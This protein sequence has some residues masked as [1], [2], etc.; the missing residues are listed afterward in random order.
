MRTSRGPLPKYYTIDELAGESGLSV[1]I[2]RYYQ[3]RK[4]LPTRQRGKGRQER[5][6]SSEVDRLRLA[7]CAQRM[8]VPLDEIAEIL[9]PL[10]SPVGDKRTMVAVTL[11]A[12]DKRIREL[13][14]FR[15]EFEELLAAYGANASA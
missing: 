2:I 9:A 1:E 4:L 14:I 7:T 11:S 8:G 15:K 13:Q 3:Q 6:T 10:A 12:V 5:F